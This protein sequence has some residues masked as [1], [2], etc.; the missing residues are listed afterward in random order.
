ME[1][2]RGVTR[3][4]FEDIDPQTEAQLKCYVYVLQDP[5]SRHI[6]Y[7]GKG[8]GQGEGNQR[9]LDH[10]REAADWLAGR[11]PGQVMPAKIYSILSIW[12]RGEAVVWFVVRHGLATSAEAHHVEAALIDTLPLS[13]NSSLDNIQGGH[14]ALAHGLLSSSGVMH[15]NAPPVNPGQAFPRVLVFPIQTALEQGR[16]PYDAVRCCWKTNVDIREAGSDD[17]YYAVGLSR[18]LSRVVCRI[19]SWHKTSGNPNKYYFDGTV[20]DDSPLLDKNFSNVLA[21]VMGYW[22]RGNYV[23][24]AFDGAGNFQITLGAKDRDTV[25]PCI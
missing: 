17:P 24:V 21:P 18:E 8:G 2:F 16:T 5:N 9:V 3:Q 10:F 15:L 7:V 6:F 11:Y 25:H 1:E 20:I 14:H 4:N 22:M 13:P 19:D 12:S 23:G